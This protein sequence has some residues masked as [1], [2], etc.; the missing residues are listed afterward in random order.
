M[1]I[2]AISGWAETL[3][4]IDNASTPNEIMEGLSSFL[5]SFA[6]RDLLITGLPSTNDRP[7]HQAI[8][9]D[10]WST[11]WFERYATCGHFS[12]DPCVLRSRTSDKAF[13]WRE[14]A[15]T[16]MSSRQ[17]R[18][19]DEASEF[20]MLD[21][22]CVPI[23]HPLKA[24]A[25][26]TAAGNLIDV[27]KSDLP[28][29][30]MICTHAFRALQRLHIGAEEPLLSKPTEREKEIL[31]WISG[32]KSAEDIACILGIS[33]FTV[34]RHLRNVREKYNAINTVHAV[35]EAVRRGDI[36]P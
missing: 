3:E 14:L 30:E 16:E 24:P 17:L 20:G 26:V 18:V 25:V 15:R 29:L 36:Q 5:R 27:D 6:F 19:M 31:K 2:K 28:T 4:R 12:H 1:H 22:L 23:H 9:Y 33:K 21:G 8:L 7:W 35:M 11:E 13:L 10:G 34:E 32:G